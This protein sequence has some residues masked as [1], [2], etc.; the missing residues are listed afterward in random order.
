MYFPPKSLSR[1]VF[2]GLLTL[3]V[4]HQAEC[5]VA[6]DRTPPPPLLAVPVPEDAEAEADSPRPSANLFDGAKALN[7]DATECASR[8]SLVALLREVRQLRAEVADLKHEVQ[9]LSGQKRVAE[10]SGDARKKTTRETRPKTRESRRDQVDP[11]DPITLTDGVLEQGPARSRL[12]EGRK[13]G[14]QG[15]INGTPFRYIPLS[16]SAHSTKPPV[17]TKPTPPAVQTSDNFTDE[18]LPRRR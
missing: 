9:L 10:N 5:L 11:R 13:S 8:E 15:E 17:I 7:D 18:T 12:E 6:D 3:S 4:G 16:N 14:T 1:W 2:Y